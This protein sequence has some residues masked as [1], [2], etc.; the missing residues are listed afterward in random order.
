M[1]VPVLRSLHL[2]LSKW[3]LLP[4]RSECASGSLLFVRDLDERDTDD[5]V[6]ARL[7][8]SRILDLIRCELAELEG[9]LRFFALSAAFRV[10]VCAGLDALASSLSLVIVVRDVLVSGVASPG[11]LRPQLQGAM[12][13]VS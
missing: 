10:G 6:A 11:S 3:N 4:T 9:G 12:H 7:S 2:P 5:I 8:S 13:G 1:N